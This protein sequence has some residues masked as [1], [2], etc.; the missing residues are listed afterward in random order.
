MRLQSKI[1]P[2]FN[3]KSTNPL[4]KELG[5][6][7]EVEESDG[8]VLDELLGHVLGVEFGAE[9]ELQWRLLLHV[10]AQNLE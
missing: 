8:D 6:Y 3:I 2:G 1:Q 5:S 10:L 7:L 9:L 4:F